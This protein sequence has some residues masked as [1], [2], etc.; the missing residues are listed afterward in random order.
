MHPFL[1]L[2]IKTSH[3]CFGIERA[4]IVRWILFCES[5]SI[6]LRMILVVVVNT[7]RREVRHV[8][9]FQVTNVDEIQSSNDI[10]SKRFNLQRRWIPRDPI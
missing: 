6:P 7:S 10:R 2:L 4:R 9:V 1:I 3:F 5:N 8:N